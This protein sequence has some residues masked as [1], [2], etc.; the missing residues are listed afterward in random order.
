MENTKI[1][2]ADAFYMNVFTGSV[3]TGKNWEDDCDETCLTEWVENLV[4]V[5]KVNGEWVEVK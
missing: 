5:K 3:D 4:E 2:T 1:L